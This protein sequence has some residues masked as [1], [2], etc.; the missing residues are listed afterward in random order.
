M[1]RPR[2]VEHRGIRLPG[3][4][5]VIQHGARALAKLPHTEGTQQNPAALPPETLVWAGI[6]ACGCT[7]GWCLDASKLAPS[8]ERRLMRADQVEDEFRHTAVHHLSTGGYTLT[9]LPAPGCGR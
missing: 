7:F 8:L 3:E 6:A 4:R 1:A 2:R 9:H 5:T